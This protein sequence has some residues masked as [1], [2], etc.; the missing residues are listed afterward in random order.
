MIEGKAD[1]ALLDKQ[2][3]EVSEAYKDV[4]KAHMDYCLLL[5]EV[6]LDDEDAYL[7]DPSCE[8]EQGGY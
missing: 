2:Y 5:E 8:R 7:D 6:Q 3:E 4:E 1:G